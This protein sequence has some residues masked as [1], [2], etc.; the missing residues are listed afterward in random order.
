[1]SKMMHRNRI[2]LFNL[3]AGCCWRMAELFTYIAE[4]VSLCPDCGKSKYTASE[5]IREENDE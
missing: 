2:R 3:I 1:M 4:R 5:C